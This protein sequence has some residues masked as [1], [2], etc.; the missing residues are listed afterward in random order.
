MTSGLDLLGGQPTTDKKIGVESYPF[1]PYKEAEPW[2]PIV[3]TA[4]QEN[5]IPSGL[6]ANMIHNESRFNP[7]AK[8]SKG[9]VGIAQIMPNIHPDV[10]PRDPVASIKYGAKYLRQ[11]YD[12]FGNW[13]DAVAAYNAGPTNISKGVVP[14]ATKKYKEDVMGGNNEG[15]NSSGLSLLGTD[16]KPSEVVKPTPTTSKIVQNI[17]D[18]TPEDVPG[19]MVGP[20]MAIDFNKLQKPT[21]IKV[22]KMTKDESSGAMNA[23]NNLWGLAK[24]PYDVVKG[25]ADFVASLPGFAIGTG[26]AA[27][28]ISKALGKGANLN[29][30]YDAAARGMEDS[31]R[32]WHESMVAPLDRLLDSLRVGAE[33]AA[34]LVTGTEYKETQP[35]SYSDFVG[36]IAM[37]PLN[38][39]IA[40]THGIADAKWLD[41]YPN[42]RG[43]IK[44]GGD[45]LGLLTMGR[46]Y[47]G[48][49]EELAKDIEPII[50]K[51]K[52][53]DKKE[54]VIEDIPDE[55]LK[56]A[57]QSVLDTE[58]AQ[59][60]LEAKKLQ[61]KVDIEKVATEDLKSKGEEVYKVKKESELTD[62]ELEYLS[63]EPTGETPEVVK[64][65]GADLLKEESKVETVKPTVIKR[66]G[67]KVSEEV[68]TEEVVKEEDKPEPITDLDLQTGTPIPEKL[69]GDNHPFRDKD[70]E[71][72][73]IM[74]KLMQE[75]VSNKQVTP[76]V[77]TRYLM[78]E[79]NRWLNGSEVDIEKIKF[80]LSELSARADK[81][82]NSF[83]D[84]NDFR[85]WKNIVGEAANWARQTDRL[86]NKRT[87]V[88]LNMMIPLDEIP[89]RVK[90]L[91]D[92]GKEFFKVGDLYR[93]KELFD[94]TGF[95]L[96]K[97]GMWRYEIADNEIKLN[98][99]LLRTDDPN[100]AIYGMGINA[101]DIFSHPTLFEKVPEAK[102]I[103][104]RL[105]RNLKVDGSYNSEA[106]LI[107]VKRPDKSIIIHELQHAV[108]DIVGSEFKGS[109]VDIQLSK[110]NMDLLLKLKSNIRDP[111]IAKSINEIIESY[112]TNR[113]SVNVVDELTKIKEKAEDANNLDDA[114]SISNMVRERFKTDA[115]K[116]YMKDPGEMEARLA[117]ARMDMTPEQRKKNSPWETL[118]RMIDDEGLVSNELL[119]NTSL[120]TKLYSGLPLDEA[121][122]A[123]IAGAKRLSEY[124]KKARGMKEFKPS[125]AI[126]RIREEL[127]RSAVDRSGNIR[128]EL[129][130]KLDDEGYRIIQKMYLSKGASSLAAENLKQ[131]RKEVYDGLSTNEKRILDNLILADRM[132]DIGKYKTTTQF[133]F[134]EGL[135]PTES[136]AYN[137]LFQYIEKITPE[138]ATTLKE[139][140]KAYFEW[141]KKPLKDMLD[142][143]LITQEEYDNLAAHNYRRLKLVDVFDKRYQS[144]TGKTKRTVY[145]SG[146]QALS[147]GR[148]TDVFEPSSEVM[149][150]EVF[151]RA[152]GRI[153]NNGA[154]RTL[155][156]LARRDKENPFVRV[157]EDKS[158]RI[159]TGWDRVF[160]YENG[161]R[162]ALYLSPEMAKEWITNSP[163]MSYKLSQFLR[164]ASG[165]PVLRTMATGINWG[166]ALA[167]LPRDIMHT[168]FAARAFEDGKWKPIYNSSL[169]IFGM[170]MARDQMAVFSDA[171]L[172]KGR[173]Q[174]YIKEGGGMEFLVH[175]GKLMQ[176][177]RH[178]EGSID[179]FENFMGYFGETSELMTRLAIRERAI[180]KGKSP[181]ESTFIA[182]DYMD[183]GQ[184]GGIAKA[185]DNAVPYLGASIQGTRGLFRSIKDNPLIF[186]YKVAQLAALT[187][188]LLIYN[189]TN[190]PETTKA[191]QGNIDMQNNLCLPLGDSFSFQD[192][193]GQ[194]RYSYFKI[195]LDPGQRFFKMFFEG[196]T[197]KWLGNEVD[198]D[199]IVNSLTQ[200]SP[201]GISSLPPTIAG[202][203]GYMTNK[204]FW[205]NEDIWKKT[206]KPLSWPNSKEEYIPGQTPQAFIDAGSLTGLSPER[207]KY[208]VEQLVTGGTEWGYLSGQGYDA[209]FGDLP[210]DMKEKHLAE[211]LAKV[212]IVKRFIG[213][214]NPYSQFANTVEKAREGSVLDRWIENRGLD[215][216][217]EGYLY[218]DNVTRKEVIDYISKTAKDKDT[219]DRLRDRFKFQEK[220][221]DL[222]NRS[223]WLALKGT[224]DTDARA[225]LYM[226]RLA[227]ATPEERHQLMNEV[228]IVQSAGGVIS[229]EFR[230]SVMK[231]KEGK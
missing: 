211:T 83:E 88:K 23:L 112:G 61:E 142:A 115:F 208:A 21:D 227:N 194:T 60:E 75:K 214:T 141:M 50:D 98:P 32:R 157:K 102:G 87:D 57:Q 166:F 209:M 168:W 144:K 34:A 123:I 220:I 134:P 81:L 36:E 9:A 182:R 85:E 161:E 72:T 33:K 230:K 139:R 202:T 35:K 135:T 183:F 106:K 11:L 54:K 93:N 163:E 217:V 53:I 113:R 179:K 20:M 158:D 189:R 131:M 162:K 145:D 15:G 80:G 68:P 51:A 122:K 59:L 228:G 110:L 90:E 97:D 167:N 58:K 186:T 65:Y 210:K 84:P 104:I 89:A 24:N 64:K 160:V 190:N 6:F 86:K 107:D 73:E 201:V 130:D 120:G 29:Q 95:W 199:A 132:I 151:N 39:V 140:S 191:L 180:R 116:E 42:I 205:L 137:E 195:P 136:A 105:N 91:L 187:S 76:E 1:T 79:V 10:N 49:H 224:P 100:A 37:T 176:R 28:E 170:Q 196:A 71:H 188:G 203:L 198:T 212:P 173:Y 63:E 184:G 118:E 148:E 77:F 31:N 156:D 27:W 169:P 52:E 67:K 30:V 147:H 171:L 164:Y 17:N 159:P 192:E 13:G 146:V 2:L 222:P 215:T 94:K 153:L 25:T 185:L 221:K 125:V 19:I 82:R 117:S 12:R 41:E 181:Q 127:I 46:V 22:P 43:A 218:K 4:E 226:N 154:N 92:K 219:F 56:K 213:I 129:L 172:R 66:K 138:Q 175:Q 200:V 119:R 99:R 14:S 128:R 231:L 229:D 149:A 165:S 26:S 109:N 152:Y 150:L 143:E 8:S 18:L 38:T 7:N 204:N 178:V 108:N 114:L 177:G 45:A 174:D 225:K 74:H 48:G 197:D 207:M 103:R 3:N 5:G 47:K 69:K 133:K 193:K 223:F 40:A 121:T 111:E 216:L 16:N 78:N 101:A 70:S 124:T 126:Q 62:E 44:F 96:G 55:A 155:L 206:D